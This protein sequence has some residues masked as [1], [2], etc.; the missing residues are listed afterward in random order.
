MNVDYVISW[1]NGQDT[2]HIAARKNNAD[3]QKAT[4]K[5]ALSKERFLDNGE[6]YYHLAS[7]I[8]YAPFVRRI[9]IVS[10]NQKPQFLDDFA[11]EN[12]C[13]ADFIK[14]VSHD[15]IFHGLNVVRPTFNSLSIETALW[16]IK[17]ISENFIY[18]NDDFFI[19]SPVNET[20]FF[21]DGE[22][23]LYGYWTAPENKKKKYRFRQFLS[24]ISPYRY[25]RPNYAITQWQGAVLAGVTGQY[26]G[27]HHYPHPLRRATLET[28]FNQNQKR[29][30]DQLS[31]RYRNIEQFN[32]VALANNIEISKNHVVTYPA[33][34]T[35]YVD[36]TKPKKINDA[37]EKII[38]SSC[39]FGCI[40]GF[41]RFD[42]TIRRHIHQIMINKFQNELPENVMNML[43]ERAQI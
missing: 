36:Y 12:K 20:I 16:R 35:A 25:T 15:E 21:K 19:N 4:H 5:E 34:D 31:Y 37:L 39:M 1:V 18:A 23:L 41:E 6:I 43:S 9:I 26:F 29:L 10:D 24:H 42:I 28:F 27:V 30:E 17:G 22:P 40:Q 2:Q 3:N 33:V 14:L 13:S 7:V 11:I 8:K 32:P 38:T